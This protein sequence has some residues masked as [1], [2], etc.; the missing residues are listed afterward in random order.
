MSQ[1]FPVNDF[2]WVEDISEFN[3]DFIKNYNDGSDKGYFLEVDV[4]CSENLHSFHNVLPFL[5]ER[6]KIEKVKNL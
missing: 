3:V 2:K 5:P 6:M 1:K 4:Q